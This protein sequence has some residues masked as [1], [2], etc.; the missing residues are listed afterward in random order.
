[1]VSFAEPLRVLSLVPGRVRLHLPGWA[2]DGRHRLE[3]E[4]RRAR[5][6]RSVQANPLT[7]NVLIHF[8]PQAT[9]PEA[10]LGVAARLRNGW[11]AR[12]EGGRRGG[13][14]R[15]LL[16]AGLRGLLGH[17]LVD[18]LI[19]TVTFTQPFGLPLAGLG[20]LHLGLDV[21]AWGVA[22]APV[23]GPGEAAPA[24]AGRRGGPDAGGP[25]R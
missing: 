16:R 3:A 4:L 20:A 15:D 23:L 6:V 22:L 12:G 2:G 7:G 14:R 21:V 19:Y 8:D 18:T 25:E 24:G 10:L 9:T 11:P 13:R 17:A 5:G 1:M